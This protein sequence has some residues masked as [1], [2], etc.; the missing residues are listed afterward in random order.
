MRI[1]FWSNLLP[2]IRDF[3]EFVRSNFKVFMLS[4]EVFGEIS[5]VIRFLFQPSFL[6]FL[7]LLLIWSYSLGKFLSVND[8][9][10]SIFEIMLKSREVSI[11]EFSNSTLLSIWFF[12]WL[13]FL[14]WFSLLPLFSISNIFFSSP[15]F[16]FVNSNMALSLFFI[17]SFNYDTFF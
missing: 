3:L 15:T 16:F 13:E 5:V 17:L 2:V 10:F 14:K 8:S 12:C 11:S 4:I 9:I 7:N 1:L 6:I